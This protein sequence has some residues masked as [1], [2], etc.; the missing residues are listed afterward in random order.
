VDERF[1]RTDSSATANFLTDAL[2][3]TLA[4]TSSSASTLAQYSYDPFG[5]TALASGSSS[6]TYEYTGREND[7]TGVYLYRNRYYSPA[8]Q[9]FLSEDPI[10]FSGGLNLYRYVADSPMNEKDSLG[11]Y[12]GV[13][14]ATAITVG[15][16][17]GIGG[18]AVNDI[19]SGQLSSPSSYV[20]AAIGGAVAGEV[21]LYFGP[22]LGG[23]A[24]NFVNNLANQEVN[25]LNGTQ[26]PSFDPQQ[27]GQTALAGAVLGAVVPD[28]AAA[29]EGILGEIQ[30]GTAATVGAG[31]AGAV[32]KNYLRMSG[33]KGDCAF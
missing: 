20:N 14:D 5:N 33:R 12:G 18:Q 31:S 23:A 22:A 30:K 6:N 9:R 19:I 16:I 7:G 29:S 28:S 26:G 4:L 8:T 1:T 3:S 17:L 11:L 27:L 32:C 24:G 10:G 13:D 21:T 25:M 15:A 2:G